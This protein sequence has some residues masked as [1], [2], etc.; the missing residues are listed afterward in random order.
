MIV[1]TLVIESLTTG[2]EMAVFIKTFFKMSN[3]QKGISVKISNCIQKIKNLLSPGK[4]VVALDYADDVPLSY[5]EYRK[6]QQFS[7][8]IIVAK[9]ATRVKPNNNNGLEE[10]GCLVLA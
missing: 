5:E 3:S 4:L 1:L 7:D 2:Q 9:A 8:T 10:S 6:R